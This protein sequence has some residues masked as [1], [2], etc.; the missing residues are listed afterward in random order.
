MSISP[1]FTWA[2]I[3]AV[4]NTKKVL[5]PIHV[6]DETDSE[7]KR[8]TTIIY[9]DERLEAL[10]LTQQAMSIVKQKL[11]DGS[12]LFSSPPTVFKHRF[13]AYHAIESQCGLL[14]G[15]RPIS[16][17]GVPSDSNMFLEVKFLDDGSTMK[18]ITSGVSVK[19]KIYK[20]M[21]KKL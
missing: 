14:H 11:T 21:K 9:E 13:E 1:K 12:V 4:G 18:A 17:Y 3:A 19:D 8:A 15:V 16:Y 2:D 20:A 10:I 7:Y 6:S 5:R